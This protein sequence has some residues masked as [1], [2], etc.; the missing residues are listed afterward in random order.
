MLSPCI[1]FWYEFEY[2]DSEERYFAKAIDRFAPVLMNY[3]N[4]GGTWKKYHVSYE[5]LLLK[6]NPI[7][8]GSKALWELTLSYLVDLLH[9][10]HI[11]SMPDEFRPKTNHSQEEI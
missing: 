6:L 10:G 7:E 9:K 8:R 1:R 4:F 11:K 5:E 3:H 2:G